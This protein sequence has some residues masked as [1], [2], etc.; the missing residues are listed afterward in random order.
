[1]E[2]NVIT[3]APIL[4][5]KS[6]ICIAAMAA[7]YLLSSPVQAREHEVTVTISV[8]AAGLDLRQPTDARE[9]YG[10]LQG[11]ARI[12]CTHGN[13]VDLKPPT[14]FAGCYQ[15][16]LG[17]AVRSINRP[18][19]TMIYLRTHTLHDAATRGIDV[20]AQVAAQ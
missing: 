14:D 6:F 20:P 11:A 10:R 13:R 4:A 2:I 16:A 7:C 3:K 15:K 1:L 17:D 19:L 18:Q 5:A 9:L 8:S 12:A